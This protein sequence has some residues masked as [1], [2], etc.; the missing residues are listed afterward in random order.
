MSVQCA[1][2]HDMGTVW[3]LAD[4]GGH[5]QLDDCPDCVQR[6][7]GKRLRMRTVE[8]GATVL[9]VTA[10][11]DD[12]YSLRV[13]GTEQ[14]IGTIERMTWPKRGGGRSVAWGYRSA[15]SGELMR[16]PEQTFFGAARRCLQAWRLP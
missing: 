4:E 8:L 1:T 14:R 15:K 11:D 2:C 16:S 13:A 7:L 6:P 5:R 12:V 9:L 3:V 10:E